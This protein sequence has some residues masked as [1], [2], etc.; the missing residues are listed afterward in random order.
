MT[1]MA[2]SSPETA[3]RIATLLHGWLIAMSV[4]AGLLFLI[5]TVLAFAII[6]TS[7]DHLKTGSK[8]ITANNGIIVSYSVIDFHNDLEIE[9]PAILASLVV[10]GS[11]SIGGWALQKRKPIAA[12]VL[13]LL[14]LV[15]LI[16]T[17]LLGL[18]LVFS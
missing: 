12:F 14:V 13:S 10:L 7:V 6:S 4:L 11:G 9:I 17:V 16:T 5:D 2:G 8:S 1:N 15:S 18:L 3:A